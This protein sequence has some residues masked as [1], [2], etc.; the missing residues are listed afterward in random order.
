MYICCIFSL[1]WFTDGSTQDA[2]GRSETS[3]QDL[4][5]ELPNIEVSCDSDGQGISREFFYS[6]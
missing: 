1:C 4:D 5:G 3:E 2:I 6:T